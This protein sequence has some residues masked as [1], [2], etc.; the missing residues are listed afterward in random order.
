VAALH[1]TRQNQVN[2]V[3]AAASPFVE[4]AT[5]ASTSASLL[6]A[7]PVEVARIGAAAAIVQAFTHD[8]HGVMHAAHLYQLF[9]NRVLDIPAPSKDVATPTPTPKDAESAEKKAPP[10]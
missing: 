6:H 3:T 4:W 8:I 9:V 2:V 5:T 1:A 10:S 7:T